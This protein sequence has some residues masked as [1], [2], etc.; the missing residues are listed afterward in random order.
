MRTFILVAAGLLVALESVAAGTGT[1]DRVSGWYA[2]GSNITATATAGSQSVFA[3]WSGN[4]N[5]CT[6]AGNQITVPVNGARS[7]AAVFALKKAPQG[8]AEA[9]LTRYG[10]TNGTPDQAELVDS[11]GDG[12]A[13]WQEYVAGTDPTN[14]NDCFQVVI[15][16]SNGMLVASF[17]TI[18]A[19]SSYYGSQTRHYALEQVSSLTST[20]WSIVP[21]YN[22]LTASGA[23]ITYTN[24]ASTNMLFYRAKVWLE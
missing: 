12:V 20:N 24:S 6:I 10:L 23:S 1:L 15:S 7:I 4:T 21:G 5:G 8:T 19:T 3:S 14:H 17:N 18:V 9:W 11:D 22:N 16:C 2:V 13:A